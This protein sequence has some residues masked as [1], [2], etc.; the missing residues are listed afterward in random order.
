MPKF[1]TV[2][3]LVIHSILQTRLKVGTHIL[4]NLITCKCSIFYF[5]IYSYRSPNLSLNESRFFMIVF[6]L[7]LLIV[8]MCRE[9]ILLVGTTFFCL[10]TFQFSENSLPHLLISQVN[11]N[12][13]FIN[14]V[15]QFLT[16][17]KLAAEL[18]EKFTNSMTV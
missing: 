15:A 8:Q 12:L 18:C 5:H 6:S 3:W 17:Q 16:D 13:W 10:N 2:A 14:Q 11:L 9:D 7:G 1:R 4:H